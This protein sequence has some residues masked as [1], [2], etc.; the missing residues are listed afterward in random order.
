MLS[1]AW[2]FR[3]ASLGGKVRHNLWPACYDTK[4]N[5]L[6]SDPGY[7]EAAVILK[8]AA[9]SFPKSNHKAPPKET[10]SKPAAKAPAS[11]A[12]GSKPARKPPATE[13]LATE[14][15]GGENSG[16][17]NSGDGNSGAKEPAAISAADN[18]GFSVR[19]GRVVDDEDMSLGSASSP[20]GVKDESGDSENGMA[21]TLFGKTKFPGPHK[22]KA[23]EDLASGRKG[24]GV[25][26]AVGDKKLLQES[27]EETAE[28]VIS[29][30]G[31]WTKQQL[32]RCL[33]RLW[34]VGNL[35]ARRW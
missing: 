1:N 21:E 19:T 5:S 2:K 3:V 29:L 28:W 10:T 35:T 32:S 16:G 20:E 14:N 24:S 13:Q 12:A 15:S 22:C 4:G 33:Q 25:V 11:K 9:K 18:S 17:G 26:K 8:S 30:V 34:R 7:G 6:A 27:R 31:C 23:E